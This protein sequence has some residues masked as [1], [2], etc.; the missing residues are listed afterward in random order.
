MGNHTHPAD[1]QWRPVVGYE[2]AYEVS[3]LGRVRAVERMVQAGRTYRTIKPKVLKG[4][5]RP[6]GY[7]QVT[8]RRK[9]HLV[10]T[11]V[12]RAF[13]GERPVGY[14]TCHN[15]GD[16]ADNRL[17]NLRYDT[18]S[19]NRLD[20]VRHGRSWQA[21]KTHCPQGHAYT[22]ENT[23]RNSHGR[24]CLTCHRERERA[25]QRKKSVRV[26]A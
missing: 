15:N 1:E 10:H 19:E 2:H 16:A 11:L 3:N 18:V 26:S 12:A 6:S 20:I 9:S 22:P 21:N 13:I 23:G 14:E 7:V 5:V 8:L 24:R 17:E 25:R 4:V